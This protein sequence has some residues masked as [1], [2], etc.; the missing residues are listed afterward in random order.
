VGCGAQ[1]ATATGRWSSGGTARLL[2]PGCAANRKGRKRKGERF[3]LFLK[4]GFKQ[5]SNKL[6]FELDKQK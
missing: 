4:R 6:R 5:S 1:G 2:K 3:F